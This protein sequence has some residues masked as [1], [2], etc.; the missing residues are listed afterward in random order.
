MGDWIFS[1]MN[2]RQSSRWNFH[3]I[4]L[5]SPISKSQMC[6][7][8]CIFMRPKNTKRR[9]YFLSF[10]R[11]LR[12]FFYL[13]NMNS[14]IFSRVAR[15]SFLD[16]SLLENGFEKHRA[17]WSCARRTMK[18][19]AAVERPRGMHY[20]KLPFTEVLRFRP[21][22]YDD[23]NPPISLCRVSICELHTILP[24]DSKDSPLSRYRFSTFF[25]IPFVRQSGESL[26]SNGGSNMQFYSP[27]RIHKNV[28]YF[29]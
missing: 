15:G 12:G 22:C 11:N 1:T 5:Q 17:C 27:F 13:F 14:S 8:F 24:V 6:L 25:F 20:S 2:F 26:D 21:L 9:D 29:P 16:R 19:F 4:C 18:S 23:E 7:F 10:L 28:R 3:F